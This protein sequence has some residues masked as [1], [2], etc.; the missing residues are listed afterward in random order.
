[1]TKIYV[2]RPHLNEHDF[3]PGDYKCVCGEL[4]KKTKTKLFNYEDRHKQ[5]PNK[6]II[7]YPFKHNWQSENRNMW[8]AELNGNF[9]ESDLKENLVKS[10]LAA[11][12][13]AVVLCIHKNETV[14]VAD[15][16]SWDSYD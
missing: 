4:I 6:V 9:W 3:E 7:S 10:A 12:F 5:F 16:V 2:C 1:M 11:E 15:Y 8:L 13:D 14:S